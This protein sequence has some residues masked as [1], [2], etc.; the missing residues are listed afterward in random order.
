MEKIQL[1][2]SISCERS[3][4]VII[5]YDDDTETKPYLE[6]LKNMFASTAGDFTTK[7]ETRLKYRSLSSAYKVH[8]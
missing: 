2:A 7:M 4:L 1:I 8:M 5:T 3:I 6:G